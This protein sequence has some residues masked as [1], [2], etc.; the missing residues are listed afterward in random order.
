MHFSFSE[1]RRRCS[2][3]S[4]IKPLQV[5]RRVCSGSCPSPKPSSPSLPRGQ[6]RGQT[7]EVP[8]AARR[9]HHGADDDED[10]APGWPGPMA[11][12]LTGPRP[13]RGHEKGRVGRALQSL[14]PWGRGPG[15]KGTGSWS[16]GSQ[17]AVPCREPAVKTES[18]RERERR[19]EVGNKQKRAHCSDRREAP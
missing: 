3:G 14:C 4:E 18:L 19:G 11:Q 10:R 2:G 16:R 5:G 13:C 1:K 7:P 8:A 6:G 15:V 12:T 9:D 17:A